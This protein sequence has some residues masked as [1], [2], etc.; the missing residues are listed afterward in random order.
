MSATL[1]RSSSHVQPQVPPS[2]DRQISVEMRVEKFGLNHGRD[3]AYLSDRSKSELGR[4]L[5]LEH[6]PPNVEVVLGTEG[7]IA[8]G[9]NSEGV[10][11][12]H[13][14]VRRGEGG[15]Y[16]IRPYSE[17]AEVYVAPAG[18]GEFKKVEGE[19]CI[20]AGS[21]VALGCLS[22]STYWFR[23][24]P[25]EI[26]RVEAGEKI[27][28]GRNVN[29][30]M[31]LCRD[32]QSLSRAHLTVTALPNGNF[33]VENGYR[34]HPSKNGVAYLEGG[35]W[36][37]ITQSIELPPGTPLL[38]AGRLMLALPALRLGRHDLARLNE[39]G[40]GAFFSP[41]LAEAA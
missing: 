12:L 27:V 31:P 15:A 16:Y 1:Q 38:L 5:R 3:T 40:P 41:V 10:K 4:N 21:R 24:P 33:L 11:F 23:A 29:A 34:G 8:I 17:E 36:V 30:E 28:I 6:L 22:E 2:P 37:E 9:L 39:F 20:L 35:H 13:L 32:E 14:I 26:K 25:L 19:I 7:D 18:K